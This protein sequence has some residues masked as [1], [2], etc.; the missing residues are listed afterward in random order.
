[1]IK[2]RLRIDFSLQL[3]LMLLTTWIKIDLYQY[4]G[5]KYPDQNNKLTNHSGDRALLTTGTKIKI[6]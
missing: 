4:P 5:S 3:F 1:M 6:S 2:F